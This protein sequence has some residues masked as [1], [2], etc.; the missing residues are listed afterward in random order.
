M[1]LSIVLKLNSYL[2]L[3]PF[4]DGLIYF[5][6]VYLT[7]IIVAIAFVWLLSGS[8]KRNMF[9]LV[10]VSI[11]TFVARGI[12]TEAIRLF[13]NR[14]RPFLES[15]QIH[16]LFIVHE[17]SFPS[18]H[19]TLLFAFATALYFFDKR[20]GLIVLLL[21]TIVVLSRVVAGVHYLSDIV[22]GAIIGSVCAGIVTY[23]FKKKFA[24]H[25]S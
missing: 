15:S 22:A 14:P 8:M 17:W 25:N 11:S 21:S 12:V 18:G 20:L 7:W 1:D 19:A 13:Y 23:I 2:G 5:N 10:C 6:A 3:S 24:N 9:V 16:P 4:Y